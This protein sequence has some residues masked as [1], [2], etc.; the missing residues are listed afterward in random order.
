MF[1][2]H[3]SQTQTVPQKSQLLFFQQLRGTATLTCGEEIHFKIHFNQICGSFTSISAT[4]SSDLSVSSVKYL[5]RIPADH[6]CLLEALDHI[7]S[8]T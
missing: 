1:N 3:F 2:L 8:L 5:Y 4:L 7:Q 6:C